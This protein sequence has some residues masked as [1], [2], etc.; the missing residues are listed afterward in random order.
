MGYGLSGPRRSITKQS[1]DEGI[2][3]GH[4]PIHIRPHHVMQTA[5]LISSHCSIVPVG[6]EKLLVIPDGR[7]D[8]ASDLGW[9]ELSFD[10]WQLSTLKRRANSLLFGITHATV[11]I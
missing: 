8:A 2:D 11:I 4:G 3:R 6:R 10:Q 7:W 1:L 5:C 9:R